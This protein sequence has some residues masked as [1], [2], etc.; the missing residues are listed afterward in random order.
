MY[1]NEIYIHEDVSAQIYDAAVQANYRGHI[2]NPPVVETYHVVGIDFGPDGE[3]E[4]LIHDP[5]TAS[6]CRALF[7]EHDN[8]WEY[9]AVEDGEHFV[10]WSVDGLAH[11][12][13]DEYA[14]AA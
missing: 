1:E 9:Y 3:H 13:N 7:Y 8:R 4:V 14:N 10:A 12:I 2:N 5:Q 6:L 11:L